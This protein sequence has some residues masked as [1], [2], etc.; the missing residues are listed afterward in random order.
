M[1]VL[2]TS[3][4][5][6]GHTLHDLP[7][8]REHAAFLAWL[9][10]VIEAEDID[11]VLVTGDVFDAG[12]PP[13]TALAAWYGFL[14]EVH[15]RRPHITVVAIAGNHD[16]PARLTAPA[17]VLA[18]VR[19]HVIGA[20]PRAAD[21]S[22]D[23]EGLLVPLADRG[24]AVR[25]WV[26]AV[27]FLRPGELDLGAPGEAA[28]AVFAAAIA[29]GSARREGEQALL[30]LGHLHLTAG[31]LAGSERA[32]GGV[33]ALAAGDLGDDLAYVALGHLHRAQRV[34]ADHVRYAGSPIPL[35][36]G[37][38]D[39][40]HQ[41]VVVELAGAR[42]SGIRTVEVP[43]IVEL[44]RIPR[45]D[46]APLAEVL[47]AIDELPA[48]DPTVAPELR[49]FLEVAVALDAPAPRL[50]ADIDRAVRDRHARLVKVR[51]VPVGDQRPL[52]DGPAPEAL[53]Q[54]DPLEVL[55]RRWHSVHGGDAPA[56]IEAAFAELVR[57]LGQEA[58]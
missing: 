12:N 34:G 57:E 8:E 28:R 33:D 46:A 10:E 31:H 3:D 24:G 5:H 6:L 54:L 1:R 32:I 19:T 4:W 58:T 45:R 29:A 21:G 48:L 26:A 38:A 40:R 2:H 47:A 39:Y 18:G 50:H 11:A 49:P 16:S 44:I 17:A 37:E 27:P 22:L 52:A 23:A 13:A 36:M 9:L 35:A 30:L 42:A 56:A 7:R 25:A 43:R 20:V 41:V 53:A 55:R 14:A 51:A 15:R